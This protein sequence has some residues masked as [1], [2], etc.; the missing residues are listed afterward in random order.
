M[1]QQK[2]QQSL[3]LANLWGKQ[4]K[5]SPLPVAHLKSLFHFE[6]INFKSRLNNGHG[7]EH[8]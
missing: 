2:K 1:T 8:T 5:P 7:N 3:Y 6:H 4:I